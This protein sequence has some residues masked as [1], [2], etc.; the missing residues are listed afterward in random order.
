MQTKTV[1]KKKS[2]KVVPIVTSTIPNKKR[3]PGEP[4]MVGYARVSMNDQS[5]QRQIDDLVQSG[6]ANVD[7]FTDTETGK[8]MD[9]SGWRSCVRD[10]QAGDILVIHSLDRLSRNLVDTMTVLQELNENGIR[11]K[12]L[13]LDFDSQTPMG[14]FVF[15]MMGAFAHYAEHG[16]MQSHSARVPL[17]PAC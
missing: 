15:A 6:V 7:I 13:T 10:L 16:I 8:H 17:W 14:R 5:A 2:Y 12:V 1:F 9:R 3:K 4:H 11:L